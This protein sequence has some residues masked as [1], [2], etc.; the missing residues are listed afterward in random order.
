MKSMLRRMAA[1]VVGAVSLVV[2]SVTAALA[3]DPDP[4]TVVGGAAETLKDE[5]LQVAV[6]VLPYAAIVTALFI[7][8]RFAKRF[9]RG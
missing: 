5:I 1:V 7:G 6:A 8:W 3:Q 4:S 2:L 9:V